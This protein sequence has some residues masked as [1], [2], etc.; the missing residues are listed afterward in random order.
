M[1][2]LQHIKGV[3]LAAI[4]ALVLLFVISFFVGD[5]VRVRKSYVVNVKSDSLYAFIKNPLNFKNILDGTDDLK[6]TILKNNEGVQY[7]GFDENLHTFKYNYLDRSKGLELNYFKNEEEQA[8]FKYKVIDKESGSILDIEK[9]W[10]IAANPLVKL[11]SMGSDE[12]IEEGMNS[13]VKLIKSA[14]E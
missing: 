7:I 13:D 4:A 6:I 12:D 9:I 11:L 10:K 5:E 8:V 1:S 14:I 2:W 3:L